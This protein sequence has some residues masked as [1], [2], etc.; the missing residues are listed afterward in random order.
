MERRKLLGLF[1]LQNSIYKLI[2][3]HWGNTLGETSTANGSLNKINAPLPCQTRLGKP[4]TCTQTGRWIEN[5]QLQVLDTLSKTN[6]VYIGIKIWRINPNEQCKTRFCYELLHNCNIYNSW[7]GNKTNFSQG[8]PITKFEFGNSGELHETGITL[9]TIKLVWETR[10][11]A[12]QSSNLSERSP[13]YVT[14]L[15]AHQHRV[16]R[17]HRDL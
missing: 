9:F 12:L 10:V 8:E 7:H 13:I 15:E 3:S 11:I 17:P 5:L 1:F 14:C 2:L 6:Q 4:C 16:F